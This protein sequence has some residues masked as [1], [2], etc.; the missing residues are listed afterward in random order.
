MPYRSWELNAE[1][2]KSL[3]NLVPLPSEGGYYAETYRS[4]EL[5]TLK[6]LPG[7]YG[8]PRN[9]C[10]AIYY[11]LEPNTF[12]PLHFVASD[13]I[14]HFYLGDPVEML[15]L[16]PDGS[17]KV[18]LIGSD[19]ERGMVPQVVVPQGVWQGARL[20]DGGQFAL[21]GCTVS[22]GFEFADYENG[23]RQLLIQA[24]PACEEMIRTLTR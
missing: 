13:E 19:I 12:S 2:L 23:S 5:I 21:L 11:L 9:M 20:V 14:F 18:V 7:R 1:T 10:T 16:L 22:P 8:G 15:Q 24:Y 4:P 17:S 6:C 3:L